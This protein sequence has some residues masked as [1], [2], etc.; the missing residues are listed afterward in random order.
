M[1]MHFS[2]ATVSK[3]GGVPVILVSYANY[4]YCI[5]NLAYYY[6]EQTGREG[7]G[8]CG[9]ETC[10]RT[11]HDVTSRQRAA[12]FDYLHDAETVRGDS[13]LVTVWRGRPQL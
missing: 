9:G 10:Q 2:L 13:I 3:K 11:L 12:V 5:L 4:P 7:R 1:I 8:Y 6:R